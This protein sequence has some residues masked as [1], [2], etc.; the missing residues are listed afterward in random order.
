MWPSNRPSRRAMRSR[1]SATS[2]RISRCSTASHPNIASS[3]VATIACPL[4]FV[5]VATEDLRYQ[6]DATLS[7]VSAVLRVNSA[8]ITQ[9]LACSSD[10]LPANDSRG[11][12]VCRVSRR[13]QQPYHEVRGRSLGSWRTSRYAGD[14]LALGG[15]AGSR[16]TAGSHLQ[17]ESAV[18]RPS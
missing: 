17:G 1:R 13:I 18:Q 8:H 11:K 12:S 2:L 10:I 6:I 15:R 7:T 5:L 9:I 4:P 3:S 14:S 16:Y